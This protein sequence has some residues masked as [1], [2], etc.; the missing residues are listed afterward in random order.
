MTAQTSTPQVPVIYAK[1]AAPVRLG[2]WGRLW[3]AFVAA[4]CL[5]VLVVATRVQPS[6]TGVGSHADSLGLNECQWLQQAGVP[7]PSCGMTT[8]FAHFVR[9]NL[10]ASVYVQPMGALL[11]AAAGCCVLGGA[12]AAAS[13]RPAHRLLRLLP[14][15][16]YLFP[17]LL[18]ALA[19]WAWKIFIHLNGWDGPPWVQ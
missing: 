17:T 9:G 4:S 18:F 5:A 2:V 14:G 12:Y 3:S 13:G 19:A 7:C 15:R 16:Y 11:A 8:A 1:T 10:P 6:P